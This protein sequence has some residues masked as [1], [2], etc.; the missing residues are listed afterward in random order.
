[1]HKGA[2]TMKLFAAILPAILLAALAATGPA[3]AQEKIYFG[4]DWLAEAEYGGY[5]QAV[6]KGFY[7]RHGL[8]VSIR[9]GGPSA[10]Q[11]QLLLAGRYDIGIV[12]NSFIA[13]NFVK[14]AIPFRV[15]AAMFQKDPSVLIAHPGQ[16]NDSFVAL[17]GKPIMISADT[18]AGWWNF[19]RVR[20]GYTDAQI[21]P[22][23]FNLQPFLADKGAVQQGFLGSE[24]FSI[25]QQAGFEPVVLLVADAGFSGYAQHLAVSERMIT[26]RP[27]LVQNFIDASIEGWVSYL[28]SDPQ[29]ADELMKRDNPEMTD[30]LL[31]YGRAA[32]KRQ[33]IVASGDA[34]ALGIGAMTD[35]RWKDLFTTMAAAGLYPDNLDYRRAYTLQFVNHKVGVDR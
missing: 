19:L 21:R 1:M 4:T 28:S 13:L 33:G 10:N 24:P 18:R 31:A 11:T 7:R 35:A 3:R 34:T 17:R 29:P 15:V 32:L 22:Y 8:D 20:F 30:A 16:G 27:S 23:N 12:S 9:Q 5:Y 14:E 26:L 25:R 2:A 6:A